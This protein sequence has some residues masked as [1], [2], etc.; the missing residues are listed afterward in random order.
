MVTCPLAPGEPH[1]RSGSC[2]SPCIFI[3]DFLQTPPHDDALVLLL[4]LGS[5]STWYGDSHP[6]SYVPCLA[7][8]CCFTGARIRA[9]S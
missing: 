4:T 9:S 5:A 8:T 2:A 6:A 3:L 7:R 1:L